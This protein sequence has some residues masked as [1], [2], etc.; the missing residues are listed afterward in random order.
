MPAPGKRVENIVKLQIP[1]G[2]ATPAPPV[3]PA[4]GEAKINIMDFCKAFND[5]TKEM[6]KGMKI[7]VNIFVYIDK[8]FDFILKQPPAAELIKKAAGV[9]KGSGTPNSQKAGKITKD[10]LQKIAETKMP[11]LNANDIDAA[12]NIIAGTCQNMG[13]EVVEN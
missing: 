12:M 2:G 1:A 10:Q 8:S 13:I 11:D 6:E 5:A 3:G 4:L 7:P 9:P